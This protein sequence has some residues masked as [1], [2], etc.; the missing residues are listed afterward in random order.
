MELKQITDRIY[1]M[2]F[3]EDTD[4]PVLSYIKGDMYALVIDSGN[5]KMHVEQ[6]YSLLN[7]SGLSQPDYTVITHYHWDHTFG[8]N[9]ISGKSIVCDETNTKLVEMKKWSWTEDDM[10]N[11]IEKGIDIEFCKNNI[12]KEYECLDGIKVVTGDIIF[13]NEIVVDL[14]GIN[15]FI[16]HIQSPHTDDAV[17]VYI[18]SDKIVFVGDAD[19]G[20][21]NN[22]NGKYDKSKLRSYI[23]FIKT[24]DF[25]KYVIGHGKVESKET[26]IRYLY[27]Q[28][29]E[30]N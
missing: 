28:L 5:S 7:N 12:V 22:L 19:C 16:K 11:R 10:N 29:S 23:E 24:L 17:I 14:G 18:P 3:M 25:D 6:F 13:K 4:R 27:E 20:D 26:A 30:I 1:Y 8:M 21:F 2:E 9:A 15:C